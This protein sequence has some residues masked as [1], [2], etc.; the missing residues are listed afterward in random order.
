[1]TS[2]RPGR[3]PGEP[4]AIA[5]GGLCWRRANSPAGSR[6]PEGGPGPGSW[7]PGPDSGLGLSERTQWPAGPFPVLDSSGPEGCG[8]CC[9]PAS[10]ES[11][12]QRL[13]AIGETTGAELHQAQM[14][15]N[16]GGLGVT[17]PD[18][19]E[20]LFG[21]LIVLR[22]SGNLAIEQPG[23]RAHRWRFPDISARIW[24]ALPLS[25]VCRSG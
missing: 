7:L 9:F 8:S 1:M 18:G 17:G 19:G 6:P 4:D 22:S 5:A 12:K 21:G 23:L 10:G 16:G 14:V 25:P 20:K 2:R 3:E 13:L 11:F 15:A 24:R